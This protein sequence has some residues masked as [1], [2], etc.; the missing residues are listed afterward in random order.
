MQED[1]R[2]ATKVKKGT[3]VVQVGL[4]DD[5]YLRK[6]VIP[7]SYLYH[8]LLNDLLDQAR[9]MYGYHMDGPLRLPCSVDEFVDLR[10]RIEREPSQLQHHHHHH[11]QLHYH[12]LPFHT[13]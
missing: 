1:Q 5:H 11:G 10:W 6:F 2:R 4:E 13:C 8:P 12:A 9:E 7:I 3:L